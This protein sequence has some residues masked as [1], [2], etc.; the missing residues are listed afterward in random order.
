M[1]SAV[2]LSMKRPIRKTLLIALAAIAVVIAGWV[3]WTGPG[4]DSRLV[5]VWRTLSP[6]PDGRFLVIDLL[7]SGD[8]RV[9]TVSDEQVSGEIALTMF[10]DI[11]T[12]DGGQYSTKF[13]WLLRNSRLHLIGEVT[14]D[15]GPF[16]VRTRESLSRLFH[17]SSAFGAADRTEQEFRIVELTDAK[18][19]LEAINGPELVPHTLD[20]IRSQD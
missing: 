9:S 3:W 8:Y 11:T 12:F 19:Q 20:L 7:E 1:N 10:E 15:Q 2:A 16:V 13:R 4:I 14:L 18:L 5:G 6:Q 17:P